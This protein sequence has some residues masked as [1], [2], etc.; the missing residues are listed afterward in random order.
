MSDVALPVVDDAAPERKEEF[1][2]GR[3]NRTARLLPGFDAA[4]LEADG[5]TIRTVDGRIVILGGTKK[6]TLY[7][8]YTLLEDYLGC[9]MYSATAIDVPKRTTITLP[10]LNTTQVPFI[11]HREVH[12][13][14]AMDRAYS[15]WHKVHSSDDRNEE[16]GML[17]HTFDRLVPA[18]NFFATHPEFF[19]LAG[20]PQNPE[21]PALSHESR[22][23][24]SPDRFPPGRHGQE[25][26]GPVL[27]RVAE[28]QL[29]R[30][31]V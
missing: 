25:A 5:F 31:P 4:A 26:V 27:V 1:L 21:R 17:V 6:G 29:Q 24:S 18:H 28:R 9:R 7:G 11:R 3:T 15:E 19:S 10:V 13:L 12:Y 30:M 16:W 22:S 14:N 20:Q 8:V 2:L 23:L